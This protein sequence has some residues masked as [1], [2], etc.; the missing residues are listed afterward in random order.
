MNISTDHLEKHKNLKSYV[1]AKFKLLKFQ[2]KKSFAF[3]KKNDDLINKN[4]RLNKF[5]SKIT[6]VDTSHN[7]HFFKKQTSLLSCCSSSRSRTTCL[8]KYLT[9]NS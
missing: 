9:K 8:N 4:L 6:K 3:V 1:D 7:N 2:D 5:N